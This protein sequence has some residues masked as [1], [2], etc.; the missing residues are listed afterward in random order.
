MLVARAVDCLQP[1]VLISGGFTQSIKI[2]GM[3]AA[4]NT[5][6]ANGG[7]FPLQNM[8]LHAGL[9]NGGKVE[10]HLLRFR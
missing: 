3:A 6:I 1:N 10:W 4:F 2:A 8:H 5:S 7:G 9:A